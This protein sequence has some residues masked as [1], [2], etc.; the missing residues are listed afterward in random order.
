MRKTLLLLATIL[1]IHQSHAEG[2]D[3]KTNVSPTPGAIPDKAADLVV[4]G[5]FT[6]AAKLLPPP[7]KNSVAAE[8]ADAIGKIISVD[9]LTL[10]HFESMIGRKISVPTL[11]GQC[12]GILKEIKGTYLRVQVSNNG[13]KMVLPV[14]VKTLPLAYKI[15]KAGIDDITKSVCY[16][17]LCFSRGAYMTAER[18]FEQTGPF[19]DALTEACERATGYF[20]RTLSACRKGDKAAVAELLKKGANPNATCVMTVRNQKTKTQ[21]AVETT[22][23]I[24]TI[25]SGNAAMAEFLVESGSDVNKANSRDVT[26]LMYAIFHSD[27]GAPLVTYLLKHKANPN[28]KDKTGNTPL[29]G[30]I[31]MRKTK[32]AMTLLDHGADPNAPAAKGITPL[33]I[34]VMSNNLELVKTLIA[35]GADIHAKTPRGW[36]VLQLDRSRLSPPL[37]AL[38]GKY[39]PPK[40]PRPPM[41]MITQ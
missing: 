7:S 23:L 28:V 4:R 21:T 34:A 27:D 15:E 3:E 12:S 6:E 30:S 11:K 40:K 37:R 31:A 41:R 2:G 39:A 35:K 22:L 32:T 36:G 20:M 29:S 16:G 9:Q 38:L 1:A 24:E 17:T 13:V 19:A 14:S 26:P 33:M 25:K 18:V 5:K 8:F 10:K